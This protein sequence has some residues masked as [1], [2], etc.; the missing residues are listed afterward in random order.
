STW[1]YTI[2]RNTGLSHVRSERY[3]R[4]ESIEHC[5]Q[6]AAEEPAP[7][8]LLDIG[9]LLPRLPEEQQ[10]AV[11]LFYLQER[12]IQDVA[13]MMD[14]PEGTVKSYPHRARRNLAR[15]MEGIA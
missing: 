4:T 9:R 6:S 12:S 2:A 1:I 11:R 8:E 7:T 3:R 10:E 5:W 15:M 13:L 14:V